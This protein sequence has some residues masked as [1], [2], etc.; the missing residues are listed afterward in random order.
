MATWVL[1]DGRVER[2]DVNTFLDSSAESVILRINDFE[3]SFAEMVGRD[4]GMLH[5]G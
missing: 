2:P 5:D 3:I 1:V 4:A